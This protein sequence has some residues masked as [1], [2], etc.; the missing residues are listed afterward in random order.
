LGKIFNDWKVSSIVTI[1][2]GRPVDAKVFGDP[3]QDG[4]DSNDRL[5]GQGRNAFL[6]PDYATTD[7]RI[8]RHLFRRDRMKLDF[9]I[10]SFNLFNRDNLR[11]SITDD[12]FQNTAGQFVYM[13]QKLGVNYYPAQYRVPANFTKATNAYAPR[14]IQ[15]ALKFAF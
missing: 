1:G 6:G 9:I 8:T 7:M 11:V 3:N 10:E 12:S 14:Q 4:N 13:D 15:L 5:P 2:S